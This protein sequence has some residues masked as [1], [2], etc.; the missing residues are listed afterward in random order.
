M[1]R[2]FRRRLSDWMY[3]QAEIHR[4]QR[5]DDH[6]L[7]DMGIPRGTIRAAVLGRRR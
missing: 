6:L 7:Q 5:L 4:L 1:L 3:L 2:R